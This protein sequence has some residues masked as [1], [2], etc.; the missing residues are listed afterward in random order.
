[1]EIYRARSE[2][3]ACTLSPDDLKETEKAWRKLFELSLVSREEVPGGLRLEVH[4][5]SA[6][7]LRS[8]V[9]IERDCCSWITFELED[10]KSTRLNSSHPS[11]SYAVFCLKK[12]KKK[13]KK[14]TM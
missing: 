5:G 13:R 3:I 12:K 7:A 8:L 11:I 2:V 9:D 14:M 10:R 1:M 6:G 4:P